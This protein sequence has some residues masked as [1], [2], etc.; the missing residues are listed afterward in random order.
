MRGLPDDAAVGQSPCSSRPAT[1]PG[2]GR[3]AA[4]TIAAGNAVHDLGQ[5]RQRR[6]PDDPEAPAEPGRRDRPG[7][8]ELAPVRHDPEIGDAGECVSD[9]AVRRGQVHAAGPVREPGDRDLQA[10]ARQHQQRQVARR[11]AR[12]WHP[13]AGHEAPGA[14]TPPPVAPTGTI[15][16]TMKR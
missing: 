7:R 10:D 12:P 2:A 14:R 5:R 11:G 6:G 3:S 9:E 8:P 13:A 15:I 4:G 1:L 16:P